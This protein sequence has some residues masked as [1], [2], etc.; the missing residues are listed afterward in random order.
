MADLHGLSTGDNERMERKE[1][2]SISLNDN[3]YSNYSTACHSR[4]LEFSRVLSRV[5]GKRCGPA[6]SD[7]ATRHNI[8]EQNKSNQQKNTI[9]LGPHAG[10]TTPGCDKSRSYNLKII[11]WNVDGLNDRTKILAVE[12]YLWEQQV[13]VAVLTETHLFDEDMEFEHPTTGERVPI[14]AM[15]NFIVANWRNRESEAGRRK[16]GVLILLKPGL[17]FLKVPK[18]Q[19]PLNPLSCMGEKT[20]LG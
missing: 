3:K 10:V 19:M 2:P 1:I 14:F 8:S 6:P 7:S 15:K 4:D 11:T 20:H 9:P 13:D 18:S 12:T 17:D 5:E 16:G